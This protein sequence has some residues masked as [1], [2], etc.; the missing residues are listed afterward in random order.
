MKLRM[1]FIDQKTY[2]LTDYF[3]GIGILISAKYHYK[4]LVNA[5]IVN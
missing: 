4:T 5:R 2:R 3:L 1:K